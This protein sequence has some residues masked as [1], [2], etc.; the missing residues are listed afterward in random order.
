MLFILHLLGQHLL[1]FLLLPSLPL[2]QDLY[3]VLAFLRPVV[4]VDVALQHFFVLL[5]RPHV[6]FNLYFQ[7]I[8]NLL[9]LVFPS[10]LV[11]FEV[12]LVLVNFEVVVL[13]ELLFG[14]VFHLNLVLVPLHSC[15]QGCTL[16]GV[17]VLHHFF[18]ILRGDVV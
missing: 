16:Q 4:S 5:A 10:L 17:R 15:L 7:L 2:Q 3:V 6:V 8:V 11:R 12:L 18:V 13:L 9:L 14:V 1:H